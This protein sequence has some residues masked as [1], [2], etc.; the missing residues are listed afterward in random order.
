MRAANPSLIRRPPVLRRNAVD[1][2]AA[3]AAACLLVLG[4]VVANDVVARGEKAA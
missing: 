1:D 3:A 2:A 4:S